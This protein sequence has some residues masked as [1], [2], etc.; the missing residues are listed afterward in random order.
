[1]PS[2][3]LNIEQPIGIIALPKHHSEFPI[4]G[5]IIPMLTCP[6]IVNCVHTCNVP[7]Y[8]LQKSELCTS[9]LRRSRGGHTDTSPLS[10]SDTVDVTSSAA[11]SNNQR[12]SRVIEERDHLQALLDKHQIHVSE[13]RYIHSLEYSDSKSCGGSAV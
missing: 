13:V 3:G 6:T 1:M 12:L 5:K 9:S 2:L 11:V 8:L 7:H 10:A 4:H